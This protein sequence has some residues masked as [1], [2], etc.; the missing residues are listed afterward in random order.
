MNNNKLKK[1]VLSLKNIRNLNKI[2]RNLN[3]IK[4]ISVKFENYWKSRNRLILS[5]K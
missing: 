2:I 5:L 1:L 4:K 3:D